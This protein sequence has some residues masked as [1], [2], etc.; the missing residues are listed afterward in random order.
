MEKQQFI[1][2]AQHK[3]LPNISGGILPF[4]H[5]CDSYKMSMKLA[6]SYDQLLKNNNNI[7]TRIIRAIPV[8]ITN[9]TDDNSIM[10][11]AKNMIV[12]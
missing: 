8:I 9:I 1:I 10:F 5:L 12:S 7:D 3:K 2:N 6:K 4:E 11:T